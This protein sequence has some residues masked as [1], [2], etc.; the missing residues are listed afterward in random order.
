MP[1]FIDAADRAEEKRRSGERGKSLDGR[2][3]ATLAYS[4]EW[5]KSAKDL[6]VYVGSKKPLQKT[7]GSFPFM[8][9]YDALGSAPLG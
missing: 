3:L 6:P 9:G 8:L 5:E 4:P 2:H 1:E 7:D